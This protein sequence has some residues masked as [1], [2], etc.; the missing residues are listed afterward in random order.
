MYE[1]H[2]GL[3]IP[4]MVHPLAA[5]LSGPGLWRAMT[6]TAVGCGGEPRHSSEPISLVRQWCGPK[7]CIW[8]GRFL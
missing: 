3:E 8:S 1:E 2:E 4:P 5:K 7:V 6:F